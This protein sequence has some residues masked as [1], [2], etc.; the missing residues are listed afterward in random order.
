M[1]I[2]QELE[3]GNTVL[4]ESGRVV[5]SAQLV[6]EEAESYAV[7]QRLVRDFLEDNGKRIM[8]AS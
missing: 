7:G 8:M 1:K 5:L 3:Q 6:M 4:L 2:A